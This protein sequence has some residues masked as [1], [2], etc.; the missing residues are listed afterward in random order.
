MRH[1]FLRRPASLKT[2]H[3]NHMHACDEWVLAIGIRNITYVCEGLFLGLFKGEAMLCRPL[4]GVLLSEDRVIEQ[5]CVKLFK[6][7]LSLP[8]YTLLNSC[9]IVSRLESHAISVKVP[10]A[11]LL[12]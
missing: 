7:H 5:L 4:G 3:P 2:L 11:I 12:S 6:V 9:C 10:R 8:L 1:L